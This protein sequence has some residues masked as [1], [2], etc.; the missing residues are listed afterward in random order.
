MQVPNIQ[1]HSVSSPLTLG[2]IHN[3][4]T[5]IFKFVF[6]N[7]RSV[8]RCST[9]QKSGFHYMVRRAIFLFTTSFRI[10]GQKRILSKEVPVD[11]L[12]RIN[13]SEHE[14]DY[15]LSL[16]AVVIIRGVEPPFLMY[17]HDFTVVT[18]FICVYIIGLR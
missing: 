7:R 5:Y 10:S 17:I 6:R 1:L 16:I 2:H 13:L 3:S 8:S 18:N 4:V 14:A 11:I 12:S 9:S 15:V